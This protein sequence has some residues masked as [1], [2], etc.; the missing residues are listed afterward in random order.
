M[1]PDLVFPSVLVYVTKTEGN[2]NCP[3]RLKQKFFQRKPSGF[4][5]TKKN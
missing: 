2:T 3:I 5:I 4:F 1:D